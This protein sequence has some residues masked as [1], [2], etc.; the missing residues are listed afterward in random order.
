MTA[1]LLFALGLL[2]YLRDVAC[3]YFFTFN[4]PPS[5]NNLICHLQHVMATSPQHI[6]PLSLS[7]VTVLFP[8]TRGDTNALTTQRQRAKQDIHCSP[9]QVNT[10]KGCAE[11][12][13][14]IRLR[15][16]FT[17]F[18]RSPTRTQPFQETTQK[19]TQHSLGCRW[20]RQNPSFM[21]TLLPKHPRSHFRGRFKR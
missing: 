19:K 10:R 20:T 14:S 11:V 6:M 13:Q 21:E 18:I 4:P 1:F 3:T 17:V 12:V 9:P 5:P 2:P 7:K 15:V 16:S 8:P